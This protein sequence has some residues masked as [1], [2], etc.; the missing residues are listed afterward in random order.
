MLGYFGPEGTFTHQALLSLGLDEE[1]EGALADWLGDASRAKVLHDA[2]G[3]I[4]ALA[5]RGLPL[6]GVVSDTALAAYLVRPDQRS[7][8]LGDLVLRHVGRDLKPE[9]PTAGR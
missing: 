7:Y 9:H 5:A 4:N 2:K 1:A 6:R 8:D 3:P